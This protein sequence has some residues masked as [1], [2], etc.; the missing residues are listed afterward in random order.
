MQRLKLRLMYALGMLAPLAWAAG[1]IER[2]DADTALALKNLF[3]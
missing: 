3:S 1:H 2:L